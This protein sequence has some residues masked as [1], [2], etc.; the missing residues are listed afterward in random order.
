[1]GCLRVH[2]LNDYLI[3]PLKEGLNDVN[4]YVRKTAVL[5]VPKV[6]EI[7]PE[8]VIENGLIEELDKIKEKDMNSM[9]F[10][11]TVQALQELSNISKK[12]YF[13]ITKTILDKMLVSINECFEWG[14]VFLL[15]ILCDYKTENKRDSEYIIDRILP[16][17]SHV[18]PA[19]VFTAIKCIVIHM[20]ELDKELINL[21]IKKLEK[22]L[23]GL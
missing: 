5:C 16:R 9:V 6:F 2:G 12:T 4:P 7:T 20:M 22:P 1:M 11:N 23:K 14:Q 3:N 15:D 13:T 18:N 8:L 10:A 21:L 19:I 17:L